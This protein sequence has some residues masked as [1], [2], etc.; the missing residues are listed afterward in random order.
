MILIASDPSVGPKTGH[1]FHIPCF[2]T[3][4]LSI[5]RLGLFL[6]IFLSDLEELFLDEKRTLLD[7]LAHAIIS[8]VV[9]LPTSTIQFDITNL[10]ICK[11]YQSTFSTWYSKTSSSRT[12]VTLSIS[13]LVYVLV[14]NR[15]LFI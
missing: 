12:Y 9:D 15:F 10:I 1:S 6:G 14:K 7:G 5:E 2:T 4:L 8:D 3:E 13:N 11:V